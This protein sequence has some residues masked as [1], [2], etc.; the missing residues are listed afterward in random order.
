HP[1]TMATLLYAEFDAG[2]GQLRMADA[3]HPAPLLVPRDGEPFFLETAH[4]APVGVGSNLEC[5]ESVHTI[6]EGS[7]LLSFTDGLVERRHSSLD[8]G[9]ERLRRVSAGNGDDL[10]ALCDRILDGLGAREAMDDVA[11]LGFRVTSLA[12]RPL[13][14]RRP[15]IPAA[16]AEVRD[17]LRRWLRAN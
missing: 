15:A 1:G 7:T 6:S 12:G 8:D 17:V 9:F 2:S 14:L 11:I 13:H 5:N 3:G 10:D 16:V 4:A